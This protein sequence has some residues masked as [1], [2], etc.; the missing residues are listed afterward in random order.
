MSES[1]SPDVPSNEHRVFTPL[2][3]DAP[4]GF[5]ILAGVLEREGLKKSQ[6]NVHRASGDQSKGSDSRVIESIGAWENIAVVKQASSI[7]TMSQDNI[8]SLA[9]HRSSFDFWGS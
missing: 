2:L 1:A 8:T 3:C 7:F 6:S 4:Q 5:Q 9:I